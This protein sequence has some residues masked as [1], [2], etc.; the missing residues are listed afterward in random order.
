MTGQQNEVV[1]FEG[2][3]VGV[4]PG[5]LGDHQPHKVI[6]M[7]GLVA[8]GGQVDGDSFLRH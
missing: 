2:V 7:V 4:C 6:L 8:F 1:E 5:T 3:S